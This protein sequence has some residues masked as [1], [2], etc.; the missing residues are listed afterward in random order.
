M[1]ILRN[2]ARQGKDLALSSAI[3]R[4]AEKYVSPFGKILSFH[5]DTTGRSMEITV[6]LKGETEPVTISVHEY[7][8][9]KEADASFV[10]LKN[11]KSS[12]QWIE[13]LSEEYLLNRKI[14][15]PNRIGKMLGFLS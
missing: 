5:L 11:V 4:I 3:E 14:R 10:F 1:G 12:R 6:H 7:E 9:L 15:I 2:I 13:A 8:L